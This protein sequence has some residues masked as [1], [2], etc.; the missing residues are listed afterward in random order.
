MSIKF[1]A[2]IALHNFLSILTL[3]NVANPRLLR[4]INIRNAKTVSI[5]CIKIR[6][7]E[8][9]RNSEIYFTETKQ[10]IKK[11]KCCE[12]NAYLNIY[13]YIISLFCGVRTMLV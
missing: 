10:I 13:I 5:L 6:N 2:I 3:S 11:F 9:V 4:D 8:P 12:K 1:V 7:M